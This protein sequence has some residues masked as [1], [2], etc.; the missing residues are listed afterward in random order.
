MSGDYLGDDFFSED[1]FVGT[2]TVIPTATN[3]SVTSPIVEPDRNPKLIA[4][5]GRQWKRYQGALIPA[6]TAASSS[7]RN[8]F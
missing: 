1:F 8:R 3:P 5:Q 7:V 6:I 2:E 4:V